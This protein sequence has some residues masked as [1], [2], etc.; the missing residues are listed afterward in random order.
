MSKGYKYNVDDPSSGS[1]HEKRGKDPYRLV[2]KLAH[3]LS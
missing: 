2:P 1:S 3:S